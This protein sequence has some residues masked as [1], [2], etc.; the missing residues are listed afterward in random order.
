MANPEILDQVNQVFALALGRT[1]VKLTPET[2]ADQ[3]D[4]WDSLTHAVLLSE[5][6]KHFGIRFSITEALHLKNVG[7]LCELVEQKLQS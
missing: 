7:Q 1:D 5:I 2:S 6:Q 3:V 4:G